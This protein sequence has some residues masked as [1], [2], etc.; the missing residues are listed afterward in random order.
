MREKIVLFAPSTLNGSGGGAIK[1]Y[2]SGE[3]K[4][5]ICSNSIV[6]IE[7][8][9]GERLRDVHLARICLSDL[10]DYNNIVIYIKVEKILTCRALL[11]SCGEASLSLIN[12]FKF[13]PNKINVI[14]LDFNQ[15][16][17]FNFHTQFDS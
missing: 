4:A 10:I 15:E 12:Y 8:Q 1:V 16:F 7:I 9:T 3:A 17:T 2:L 11:I 13:Q 5:M 14:M 6:I